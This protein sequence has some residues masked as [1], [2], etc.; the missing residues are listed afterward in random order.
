MI[1]Y[2]SLS[3]LFFFSNYF[4]KLWSSQLMTVLMLYYD[5]PL[6]TR[7]LYIFFTANQIF[8]FI[9]HHITSHTITPNCDSQRSTALVLY[10]DNVVHMFS[11]L[12]DSACILFRHHCIH[13]FF[14]LSLLVIKYFSFFLSSHNI[15]LHHYVW[16]FTK[17][18]VTSSFPTISP[19]CDSQISTTPL[20][21]IVNIACMFSLNYW[22]KIKW[23]L[24]LFSLLHHFHSSYY[25]SLYVPFFYFCNCIHPTLPTIS[26]KLMKLS[27]SFNIHGKKFCFIFC[28]LKS[29]FTYLHFLA[30]VYLEILLFCVF[31]L[32]MWLNEIGR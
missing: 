3:R 13:V 30:K 29:K 17:A 11:L 22:L 21:Y 1:I 31:F 14:T 4:S 16:L 24:L 25:I 15:M 20:F 12:V 32:N 28:W 23:L 18:V 19:N 10:I 8:L 6:I 26:Y 5:I 7:L 2:W 27:H 9:F